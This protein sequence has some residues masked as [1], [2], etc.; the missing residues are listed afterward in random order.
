MQMIKQKDYL[1]IDI[2]YE[3]VEEYQE[4]IEFL[5]F[6]KA[7]QSLQISKEEAEKIVKEID[8]DLRKSAKEW[9]KRGGVEIDY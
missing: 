7:V 6:K 2:P 1:E 3:E 9:L 5:E 4:M 8:N